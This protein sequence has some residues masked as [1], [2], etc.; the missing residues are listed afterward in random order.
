MD[1][2]KRLTFWGANDHFE[3]VTLHF[4]LVEVIARE[5]AD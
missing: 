2:R 4:E 5:I 3:L 1:R